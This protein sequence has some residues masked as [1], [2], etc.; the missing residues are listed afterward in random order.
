MILESA[1]QAPPVWDV[2]ISTMWARRNFATLGDFFVAARR[3]GFARIE[4]NHQIDTPMLAGTDLSQVQFSSVHEPCPADIS[5][6]T[7]KE[8]DWLI[9]ALDEEKR[10]Q[11]V[12]AVKR[13]IDL[14]NDL[15]AGTI[16]VHVGHVMADLT[17]E[18]KMRLLY[19]G[20]RKPTVEY[21]ALK[22]D[23]QMTRA[24][25]TETRLDAVRKS[26]IEL[27]NYASSFNIRLGLENRYHFTDIPAP[28][29]MEM[30]LNMAGPDQLGFIYDVGHAQALDQL[31]FFHHQEW[32][33]RFSTRIIGVHLH[34]VI[35][36]EDHRAPGSGEVDFGRIAAFLP[37][38]AFRT[39]EL[40]P[41]NTPKQIRT[42]L[43]YLF[44]HHC[45]HTL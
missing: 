35:G 32:L 5:T 11:G 21:Q 31:G 37:K 45:I 27:L 23:L 42:G 20:K 22:D 6:E 41:R 26:L 18:K 28:D 19:E 44:E 29:E 8:R 3:L 14:A 4:L 25:Q 24:R 7:L 10:W 15:G 1:V 12:Q 16:V 17:L 39:L 40:H 33:D 43:Q 13:S 36:V 9:S 34:D 2:S 38:E 30:L